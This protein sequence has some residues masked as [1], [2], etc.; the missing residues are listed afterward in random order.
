MK[1]RFVTR[2]RLIAFALAL[3][4]VYVLWGVVFSP[5]G[6]GSN[7][8]L[9]LLMAIAAVYL[10]TTNV[11]SLLD[12]AMAPARERPARDVLRIAVPLL[13]ETQ[14]LL[15]E[16]GRRARA[17]AA[18]VRAELGAQMERAEGAQRALH[19]ALGAGADTETL[20]VELR[21]QL[22]QLDARLQSAFGTARGGSL[23]AQVR[24]LGIAF[25]IALALRAF[26]VEPFQIPSSSMIPTLLIG[27]HLF[28][29]RFWYGFSVPFAREPSYFTRWSSPEPGDVI[30][31][32]A[33]P[34]VGQNAGE[35]W[36]KRVIARAGQTVK[37]RD[38]I[39]YVDNEPYRF[40]GTGNDEEY[41]DFDEF[42][43]RWHAAR[44]RHQREQLPSGRTHDV[45]LSYPTRLEWPNAVP[46]QRPLLSGLECTA[47]DCTVKEGFVFVMGDN[48]DNSSDGRVWGAV[49]IDN[50][51]GRALFIW[52]SVDG[53]ERSID[54]GRF[55]LP[56][57]RF[58]RLFQSIE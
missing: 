2:G 53:S 9:A 27:D 57:F 29:A 44:A 51:K 21:N 17:V 19:D 34:W 6:T 41:R 23:F 52:M 28:V 7:V 31:F 54:L 42:S 36:I 56:A 16:R 1:T 5:Q 18:E 4:G 30:V 35:D 3:L 12:E 43:G 26:V 24:S 47:N 32:T 58:D 33:P 10:V 15:G 46:G 22:E 39:V 49:P 8:V 37:M 13:E 20:V 50:V 25:A 14:R 48:R 40:V 45:Y 55:T 38:G 11:G